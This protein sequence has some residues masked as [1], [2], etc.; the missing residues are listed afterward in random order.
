MPSKTIKKYVVC[1]KQSIKWENF[2][3]ENEWLNNQTIIDEDK[4]PKN[5]VAEYYV[6]NRDN[7]TLLDKAYVVS[8]SSEYKTAFKELNLAW[9]EKLF[10]PEPMDYIQLDSAEENIINHGGEVF[11]V[12]NRE[13]EVVGTVAM[14]FHD[15]K[16]ELAKMSV[17]ENHQGKGYSHY[18]M[19]AAITWAKEQKIFAVDLFGNTNLEN[20]I[21]IYKKYGFKTVSIGPHPIYKRV[22]IHMRWEY[23]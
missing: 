10:K 11:F 13:G 12:I 20:S 5:I 19:R 2:V 16:C 4:A 7:K 17:K 21:S 1:D 6:V 8:W 18:L 23:Q 22:D 14:V 9:I 15:G 3:G